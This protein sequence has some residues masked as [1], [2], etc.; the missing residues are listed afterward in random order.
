MSENRIEV[1]RTGSIIRDI[2][3]PFRSVEQFFFGLVVA[4]AGYYFGSHA[5]NDPWGY[6]FV[7]W[8]GG[9]AMLTITAP[10]KLIAPAPLY[11]SILY[12]IEK[13]MKYKEVSKGEWQFDAPRWMRWGN[14]NLLAFRDHGKIIITGPLSSLKYIQLMLK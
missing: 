4:L 13:N 9:S 2:L 11:S 1:R 12:F 3:F 8:A 7:A 6:A 10:A 5:D 14:S